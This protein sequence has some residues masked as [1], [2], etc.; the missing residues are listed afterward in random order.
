[1]GAFLRTFRRPKNERVLFL[2]QSP[3]ADINHTA[4]NLSPL[5]SP[6]P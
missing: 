3:E 6:P 5:E 2:P 4:D 1:L